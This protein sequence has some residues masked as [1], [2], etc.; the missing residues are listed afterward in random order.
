LKNNL[1]K[2]SPHTQAMRLVKQPKAYERQKSV[3]HQP[4]FIQDKN[5]QCTLATSPDI[6]FCNPDFLNFL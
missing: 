2:Q 3:S 1:E 6:I 5:I 4:A